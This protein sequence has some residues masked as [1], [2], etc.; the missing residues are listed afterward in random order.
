MGV[1]E[2]TLCSGLGGHCQRSLTRLALL[3]RPSVVPPALL[4]TT[5]SP[6]KLHAQTFR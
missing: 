2:R 4:H 5:L 1:K 6:F 3:R